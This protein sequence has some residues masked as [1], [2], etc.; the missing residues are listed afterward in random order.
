MGRTM[1]TRRALVLA[2]GAGAVAGCGPDLSG[3]HEEGRGTVI[4]V[5]D[6]QS[7]ELGIDTRVRLGEVLA[8][9]GREPGASAAQAGLEALTLGRTVRFA[10]IAPAGT[11]WPV[12]VMA[13]VR[14]EAGR[15][16]WLQEALVLD[17][18]V[19]VLPRAGDAQ[20]VEALL[21]AEAAA[22]A[23]N[24][25]LWAERAYAIKPADR[26]AGIVGGLVLIEG[27]VRDVGIRARA[28][29]LNFGQDWSSDVTARIPT[30]VIPAFEAEHGPLLALAGQT[31]LVRGV[32]RSSGGPALE[33][34]H[35]GQLERLS[36]T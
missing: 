33:L 4:T 5:Q 31:V 1:W 23:E 28:H 9:L 30:E 20:R 27:V 16:I 35:P 13:Y 11:V 3:L 14:S 17:G 6:G 10:A 36:P 19:R 29:Y 22:R 24:R 12:P 25:G 18:L 26:P 2:F 7:L 32:V 21:A 34:T 15:W 8:P